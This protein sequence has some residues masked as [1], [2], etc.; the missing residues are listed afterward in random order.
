MVRHGIVAQLVLILGGLYI[1]VD[2]VDV[3]LMLLQILDILNF[4]LLIIVYFPVR[5]Y[6]ALGNIM[7][8]PVHNNVYYNVL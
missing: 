7:V 2:N 4:L 5:V 1:I 3:I 8:I 6:L